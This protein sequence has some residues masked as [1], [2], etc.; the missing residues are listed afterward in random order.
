MPGIVQGHRQVIAGIHEKVLRR[1]GSVGGIRLQERTGRSLRM[2]AL[3]DEREVGVLNTDLA[4]TGRIQL[5]TRYRV[6]ANA[7]DD[8]GCTPLRRVARTGGIRPGGHV[9][10]RIELHL[11]KGHAG[12]AG[13]DVRVDDILVAVG[14]AGFHLLGK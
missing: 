3:R 9:A 10:R 11:H 12:V 2:T 5:R 1:V 13:A 14:C 4:H 7:E 8:H 6:L